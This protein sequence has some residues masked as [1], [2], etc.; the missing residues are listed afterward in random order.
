MGVLS[1]A[2]S[3]TKLGQRR[4]W[5][6]WGKSGSGKTHFIGTMPKPLLYVQVGDDGSNTIASIDGIDAI[7]A[8]TPEKLKKIGE[9]LKK[10]KK[11]ASVAVDTFSLITNVWIDA[12]SV[13][14]GKKMTQQMWGDLKIVTEE[15]IR[16]FHE[17]AA[18]HDVA[19]SCHEATDTIEGMDDEVIP[20]FAPS[21]TKGARIYIQGMANYGI[22]FT[23]LNKTVTDKKTGEEKEVVRYAAH[24]GANPYYWTKFQIDDSVKVPA[25]MLNP[26]YDK[27]M[28]IIKGG[29]D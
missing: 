16:I 27:I 17:V 29:N 18:T 4:L 8:D 15:L 26:S 11:Y 3:I 25:T 24:L 21:V 1:E 22:H 9:E 2:V 7:K 19:L 14:K 6:L 28:S 13:Q 10:D 12:N 20:D 23:K 5:V